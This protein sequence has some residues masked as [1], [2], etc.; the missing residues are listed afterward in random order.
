MDGSAF[1]WVHLA[2]RDAVRQMI[3]APPRSGMSMIGNTFAA[4]VWPRRNALAAAIAYAILTGCACTVEPAM[5]PACPQDLPCVETDKGAIL[6]LE[7]N[8][9]V[10]GSV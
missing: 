3:Y 5:A 8:D 9:E 7:C 6:Y 2:H 10:P 4:Y 1:H